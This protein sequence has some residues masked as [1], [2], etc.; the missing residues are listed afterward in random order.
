VC[1]GGISE[2]EEST[3][4]LE[5]L[6]NPVLKKTKEQLIQVKVAEHHYRAP[7]FR[8]MEEYNLA[9]PPLLGGLPNPPRLSPKQFSDQME[10]GAIAVDTRTPPAFGGVHIKGSLNIWL[11]GLPSYAGWVLPYDRAILLVLEDKQQ[12]ETAVRYLIRLGYDRIAGY[13]Y[14][15]TSGH[16][17][18]TWYNKGLPIEHLHLLSV[19]E[20]RTRLGKEKD[21]VVLD[22]RSRD[23]WKRAHIDSSLHIY[24]GHIKKQLHRISKEQELAVICNTGN[25]SSLAASILRRE[26]YRHIYNVLGGMSAWNSAGYSALT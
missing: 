13:L 2:R 11:N 4:G 17:I 19:Q 3:L 1:G 15:E 10:L 7:Y 20:L 26:G 9:G 25:R 12:V 8:K 23:E 5:R 21:M 16:G 22:V 6:Y 24:L 18:D 14:D